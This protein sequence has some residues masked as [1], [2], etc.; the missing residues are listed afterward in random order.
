MASGAAGKADVK[1]S[2][3]RAEARGKLDEA[4]E[5]AKV[6]GN[7]ASNNAP[8]AVGLVIIVL[9]C[10]AVGCSASSAGFLG[11]DD[12]L[13]SSDSNSIS[14]VT[15]KNKPKRTAFRQK[16]NLKR[17]KGR[18]GPCG[19]DDLD[20]DNVSEDLARISAALSS[21]DVI[22]IRLPYAQPLV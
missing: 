4:Q 16:N 15:P 19:S 22:D 12:D 20:S 7:P 8:L 18:P 17:K 1:V 21:L 3:K 5:A 10:L 11:T 6:E 14:S 13:R 2:L 9:C